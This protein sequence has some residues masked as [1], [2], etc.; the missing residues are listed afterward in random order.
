MHPIWIRIRG[1]VGWGILALALLVQAPAAFALVYGTLYP[2]SAFEV[3]YALDHPRHIPLEDLLDL[4]IGLRAT[5]DGFV[6]PR[7]VDRT[8]RMRL[9]SLPRGG[10]Y[11]VTAIQ[12]VTQHLVSTFNRR[13]F[14]GVI[15]MVPDI[16]EGSGRDLREP[17]DTVLTLRVWTG[18][19]S[20][21]TT[22]ADGARFEGLSVDERT[23]NAAHDWIRE[24]A[25]VQPG[26]RDGLLNVK[27]LE[28]YA[29]ETSRH[30]GRNVDVELEPGD[31]PGTTAVNLRIA[32]N[33][34]WYGFA[35][36]SNTG[37]TSTTTNRERFGLVHRQL[38]G[39]DDTLRVG[40]TTGDFDETHAVVAS[41]DTPITLDYPKLR[42]K[43]QGFWSRFDSSELGQI[44]GS[45]TGKQAGIE[46]SVVLNVF[47]HRD[48]FVDVSAGA[49]L[50]RVQIENGL[51]SGT[52]HA[53]V[54][55]LVPR[56]EVAAEQNTRTSN[57]RLSTS[58]DFGFTGAEED[59]LILLGNEDPDN[60]FQRLQINGSWSSYLE[61]LVNRQAWEDPSTPETSTLAHEI[62]L[63]F[64]AQYAF[65]NR[66]TPP[67]QEVMG[68][69]YSVRGYRQAEVSRDNLVFGSM[70]Y[71]F[72]LPR[73]L[74]PDSNPPEILGLGDFRARPPHVWG[75]PDW[76]LI[77]RVFT[78]AAFVESTS[79][80]DTEPNETL[81]SIG[82]GVELQILRN[83]IARLDAGHVLKQV[84]NSREGSTRVHV[85]GTLLY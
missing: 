26:G 68:G 24:R 49:R 59:E 35:Q 3:E 4:E 65:Q 73:F 20:Q 72:H 53:D 10:R 82:A 46:P 11:S 74:Q 1:A 43:V 51:G 14:N 78:D 45:F 16:E 18:R 69:F 36:Y 33:K 17:G 7:P 30:P 38:T 67:F 13:G 63:Q 60:D 61:P 66:L 47:Q 2:I 77:F 52:A 85:V 83:F 40:Y 27:A 57:L 55:Y 44:D 39:R 54:D 62:A 48:F 9:S 79:D 19:V 29:A 75:R 21:L 50:Q 15:V 22:I 23:D 80:K 76:D 12:H 6:A 71:R 70:E 41:Y 31:R 42:V 5:P 58:L 84:D 64:R 25:P 32:E 8:V 34:P 56:F 81:L 37:T 28:D